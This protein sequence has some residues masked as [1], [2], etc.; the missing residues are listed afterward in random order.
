MFNYK[1]L[2]IHYIKFRIEVVGEIYKKIVQIAKRKYHVS[3][4]RLAI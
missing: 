1:Y 2:L 4:S 3:T